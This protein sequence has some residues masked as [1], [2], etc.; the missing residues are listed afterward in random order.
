MEQ[1]PLFVCTEAGYWTQPWAEWEF[2]A[3]LVEVFRHN[4][5]LMEDVWADLLPW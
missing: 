5:S 1:L 2:D 3:T 4:P